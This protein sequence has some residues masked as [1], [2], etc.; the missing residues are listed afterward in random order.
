M[1][2]Y[3]AFLR[4][5]NLGAKRR[6]RSAELREAFERLRFEDVA[7]FRNSGNVVFAAHRAS[8][9][10]L[11]ERIEGAL[12]EAFGFQVR[13]LMRSEGEVRAI[14]GA[15]PFEPQA[16]AATEGRLQVLLLAK[17]PASSVSKQVLSLATDEDRLAMSGREL[18]WLPRGRM[19]DSELDV[20]AIEAGLGLTTMRTMGTVQQLA[21]KHFAT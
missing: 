9:R 18:Y 10:E 5:V 14:A 8:E 13:V 7:T 15:A 19:S 11:V 21:A 2:R 20:G 6:T 1:Q 4:G 12:G 17:R 3:A 16:L